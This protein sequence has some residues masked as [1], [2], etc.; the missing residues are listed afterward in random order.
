MNLGGVTRG[1]TERPHSDEYRVQLFLLILL[2]LTDEL[3]GQQ[4]R[5]SSS[6]SLVV[7]GNQSLWLSSD[8]RRRSGLSEPQTDPPVGDR[9]TDR[10]TDRRT[11][12]EEPDEAPPALSTSW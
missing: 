9:Q 10:R 5:E 2:F 6:L 8:Q 4:S 7:S 3:S 11:I 12:K 1:S